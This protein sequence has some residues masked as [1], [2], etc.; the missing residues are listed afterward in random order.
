MI[1]VVFE[2]IDLHPRVVASGGRLSAHAQVELIAEIGD[3]VDFVAH[4]LL[5]RL[6]G[7]RFERHLQL[8]KQIVELHQ[9][10]LGLPVG[11]IHLLIYSVSQPAI[12]IDLSRR[13]S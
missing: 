4:L 7:V 11:F 2:L 5:N 10:R 12:P 8:A 13:S 6:D 3:L 1:E 9:A